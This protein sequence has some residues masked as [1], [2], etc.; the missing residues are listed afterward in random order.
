MKVPHIPIKWLM[1]AS[2]LLRIAFF[3]FGLYQDATMEVKYT[4]I[5]YYVF[6]DA[7]KYVLEGK[8]PYLRETYR[9]TPLLAQ[10]LVPCHIWWFSFGKLVFVVCD[11]ITGW[12][13]C[14][15]TG[16]SK[17]A[18]VSICW[19]L[20]PMVIT[21]STRGS[22]E[23]LLTVVVLGSIWLWK[24]GRPI[25]SGLL[26][27][28]AI[29]LKIYPLI[30]VPTLLLS[31]SRLVSWPNF[32]FSA[33]VGVSFV[34]LGVAMYWMY[35]WEFLEH[36]YLYHWGRIDHRHNFSLY[37][38]LMYHVSS[39]QVQASWEKLISFV[40]QLGLSM[41][42]LPLWFWY[43]G[44][45]MGTTLFLQT[46]TFVTF[47][48][49]ITSQYFIWYLCLLPLLLEN[50]DLT[51][52][53]GVQMT[54]VWVLSQGIWLLFGYKLEFQGLPVFRELFLSSLVF[55]LAQIYIIGQLVKH[56]IPVQHLK[57]E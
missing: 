10:L 35:G 26:L 9:Y 14:D 52:W 25:G 22:S 21:I 4:D 8:S 48:K 23:S 3:A 39:G 13:L 18:V 38:Q 41:V 24:R 12:I 15:L 28:L 20:N 16:E 51:K 1:L 40:P 47:N 6:T 53:Q 29:H 42:V 44:M 49:V 46:F 27:G 54:V 2:L 43:N 17:R 30:Y 45:D 36:S 37:N 32:R 31:Q 33:S 11:L 34:S 19:L 5:D 55:F 50:T 57:K 56:A 7:S